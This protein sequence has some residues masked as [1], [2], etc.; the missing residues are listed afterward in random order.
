MSRNN[1]VVMVAARRS[2]IAKFGGVLKEIKA[3]RLLAHVSAFTIQWQC[4]SSMQ[5]LQ[6]L[7]LS[8]K[9]GVQGV[10]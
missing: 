9:V 5:A 10:S 6:C 4:A 7:S 8:Q 2:A 3:S 1:D